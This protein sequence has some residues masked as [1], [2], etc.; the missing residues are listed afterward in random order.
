MAIATTPNGRFR[1]VL[2][3]DRTLPADQQTVWLLRTMNQVARRHF[4]NFIAQ[5]LVGDAYER[6]LQVGLLGWENLRDADGNEVEFITE[7]K[8]LNALGCDV[9]PP[10]R[11]TLG[12]ISTADQIELIDAM[13]THNKLTADDAKN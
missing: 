1:Y 11:Q 10:T 2:E 12:R 4:L 8:T 6:A 9:N 3:K 13:Q 7:G 5:N